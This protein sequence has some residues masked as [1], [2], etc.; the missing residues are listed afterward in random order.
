MLCRLKTLGTVLNMLGFRCHCWQYLARWAR[1]AVKVL[2]I[3][4]K[5]SDWKAQQMSNAQINLRLS[6]TRRSL[7]YKLKN[8]GTRTEPCGSP[9]TCLRQ[10]LTSS[11]CGPRTG[12]SIAEAPLCKCTR[13]GDTWILIICKEGQCARWCHSSRQV[14]KDSTSSAPSRTHS[15]RISWGLWTGRRYCGHDDSQPGRHWR[16]LPQLA[17]F[18]AGPGVFKQ[19][20]ANTQQWY[21]LIMCSEMWVF[22]RFGQ[23]YDLRLSP[24][25]YHLT[26]PSI[27]PGSV[28]FMST[29]FGMVHS[30]SR[31]MW[32]V[33]VKLWD[34]LRTRAIA[35]LT[36]FLHG[37][38][39]LREC[40][41]G[42]CAHKQHVRRTLTLTLT[43]TITAYSVSEN[44][45]RV[46]VLICAT[47]QKPCRKEFT[48]YLSALE[49]WSQQGTTQIH[50][51]LHLYF[52]LRDSMYP[53]HSGEEVS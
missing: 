48:P 13:R 50:V 18:S 47:R 51:Y 46:R 39:M 52:Y 40:V 8:V 45:I 22:A 26:Q 27:P 43:H 20:V 31:G 6:V 24:D 4:E 53:N 49:V 29:S 35:G 28:L 23:S 42:E 3:S 5:V 7:V 30:V 19:L 12:D 38:C 9:F 14:K 1:S 37:V 10:E 25:L 2:S 44:G 41:Y 34:S 16:E 21:E 32:S 36:L 11:P 33:Q 15:R 17:R